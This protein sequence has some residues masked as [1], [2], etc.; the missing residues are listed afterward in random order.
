MATSG[1]PQSS[2]G[3]RRPPWIALVGFLVAVLVAGFVIFN[4]TRSGP[5]YREEQQPGPDPVETTT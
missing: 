3:K 1:S 5:N 4:A 2:A